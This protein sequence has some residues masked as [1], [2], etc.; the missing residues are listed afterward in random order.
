MT[1]NNS[2]IFYGLMKSGNHAIIHW[3]AKALL[4]NSETSGL[5]NSETSGLYNMTLKEDYGTMIYVGGLEPGFSNYLVFFND[6]TRTVIQI[7]G[8][9]NKYNDY[10]NILASVEDCYKSKER[11]IVEPILRRPRQVF[12]F[13]DLKN[14]FKSRK[15]MF[16]NSKKLLKTTID[17]YLKLYNES[18]KDPECLVILYDKWKSSKEYRQEILES[19]GFQVNE[20]TLELIPQIKIGP[21]APSFSSDIMLSDDEVK[22]LTDT[23]KF[24]FS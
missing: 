12:I 17:V 24:F 11:L 16:P 14:C 2:L 7:M 22:I 15:K 8:L 20:K 21:G 1:T 19:L 3:L 23:E 10:E 4:Y 9:I 18:Q 5:Y 6:C 13:R